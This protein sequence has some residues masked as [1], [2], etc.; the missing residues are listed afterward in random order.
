MTVEKYPISSKH[1]FEFDLLPNKFLHFF[2]VFNPN[3]E[4]EKW[5]SQDSKQWGQELK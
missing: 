2:Y 5:R 1:A 4:L 3:S